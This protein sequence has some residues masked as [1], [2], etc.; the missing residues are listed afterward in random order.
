MKVLFT[1]NSIHSRQAVGKTLSQQNHSSLNKSAIERCLDLPMTY[2]LGSADGACHAVSST[3]VD[4]PQPV[5]GPDDMNVAE[6]DWS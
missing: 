1:C 5:R 4:S 3:T 2:F 6:M